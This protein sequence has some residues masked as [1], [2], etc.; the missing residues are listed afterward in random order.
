MRLLALLLVLTACG[1]DAQ[2]KSGG[3]GD[4]FDERAASGLRVR[5]ANDSPPRL[6]TIDGYY[7]AVA[8]CM[9][10]SPLPTGP[11]VIIAADVLKNS[12]VDNKIFFPETIV[13]DAQVTTIDPNGLGAGAME[14]PFKHEMIHFLLNV[15]GFPVD[16]NT[17]HDSPF[18]DSCA[19]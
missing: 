19:H 3:F 8:A 14:F 13:I 15:T 6:T 2:D 4:S 12:G 10:I 18:F 5:Y 11:L 7:R 16:R 17:N 9:G 1:G